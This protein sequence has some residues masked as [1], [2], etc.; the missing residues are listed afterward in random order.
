MFALTGDVH[1]M[2]LNA[3][4]QALLP[5]GQTETRISGKFLDIANSHG[6]AATLYVTG[7]TAVREKE[8][9]A[10]LL[11]HY[12]FELGG[13]TYSCYRPRL[14]YGASRRLLGLSNGPKAI[15]R[16]DMKRT[17]SALGSVSGRAIT[18]WRNHA[19]RC[20]KNTVPLAAECGILGISNEVGAGCQPSTTKTRF[21]PIAS[22]P[23]NTP[24]DHENLH[25]DGRSSKAVF[26]DARSWVKAVIERVESNEERE[27]PSVILAHPACMEVVD[28]MKAFESLLQYLKRF[29]SVTMTELAKW[30]LGDIASPG[31][32]RLGPT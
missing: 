25:P 8:D 13:H 27:I 28:E 12:E 5:M 20:D 9:L 3:K 32:E 16:S 14:A 10:R 7:A 31:K 26:P 15:Q 29:R 18:A 2:S 24:P 4:D 1:D 30:V 17:I 11:R 23:I 22:L 21:G 19:Y 6:I